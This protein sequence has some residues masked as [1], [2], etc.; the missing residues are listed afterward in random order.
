MSSRPIIPPNINKPIISSVSMASTITGPATVI[1]MLPGISYDIS[2]TGTPT[3]TFTI[4]VS[5]TY[6]QAPDG[7]VTHAGNWTTL[8]QSSFQGTYPAPA[9]SAGN[10]FIDLFGISAYC[11]RL[12]YTPSGGSGNL[13]CVTCAKVW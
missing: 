2:W 12:V 11:A 5:N 1:Q 3:G 7:T 9:G 8:P 6:S 10:G 4:Q 13:T